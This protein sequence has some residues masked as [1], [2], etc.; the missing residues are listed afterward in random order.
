M[1]ITHA[2]A[3]LEMELDQDPGLRPDLARAS[4]HSVWIRRDLALQFGFR[5]LYLQ[6]ALVFK[7][8]TQKIK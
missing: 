6:R 3:R 5:S 2:K 7:I 1:T 8:V 4:C